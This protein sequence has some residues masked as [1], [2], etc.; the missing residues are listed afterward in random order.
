VLYAKLSPDGTR[1]AYV[2]D[3]NLYSEDVRSGAILP[4][5]TDGSP[6]II[7]A[8]SD[9]VYEEE[10]GLREGFFWSP[11][12]QKIAYFQFDQSG[13]PEFTLINYT[14]ALYPILTK[15]PYPKPGQTNSAGWGW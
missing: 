11:D 2:R 13:V 3:N 14:D 4:L 9:W 12:G 7:N 8:T 1:A 10:F 5:T 15:Y 6:M